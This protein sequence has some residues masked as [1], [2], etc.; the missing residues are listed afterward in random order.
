MRTTVQNITI[1][2]LAHQCKET[3]TFFRLLSTPGK[4]LSIR[5]FVLVSYSFG[6]FLSGTLLKKMFF[7]VLA[8]MHALFLRN[9]TNINC[10]E[11]CEKAVLVKA[12]PTSLLCS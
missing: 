3:K 8:C 9:F 6:L 11:L 5:S 10:V 4:K 2:K 12:S 1:Y 7:P